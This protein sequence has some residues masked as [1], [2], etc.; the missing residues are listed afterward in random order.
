MYK[1]IQSVMGYGMKIDKAKIKEFLKEFRLVLILLVFAIAL[2]VVK[3]FFFGVV[4]V[5]G[6]SMY[7]T[8]KDGE[9]VLMKITDDVEVGDIVVLH[10]DYEYEM[11]SEYIIKRVAEIADDGSVYVLGDNTEH[12]FDSRHCGYFPKEIIRG[13]VI[14]EFKRIGVGGKGEAD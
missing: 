8:L 4:K 3:Q 13:K 12:S 1:G 7:P 14:F 11:E 6:N 9:Y 10:V 2:F 5:D